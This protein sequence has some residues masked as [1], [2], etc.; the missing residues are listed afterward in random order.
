MINQVRSLEMYLR[1]S[2]FSNVFQRSKLLYEKSCN[3]QSMTYSTKLSIPSPSAILPFPPFSYNPKNRNLI[4]IPSITLL[5]KLMASEEKKK[6]T[7]LL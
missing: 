1:K 6:F 7:K 5:Q 4:F 3:E 2:V